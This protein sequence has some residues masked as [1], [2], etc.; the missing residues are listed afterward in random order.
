M[1]LH[2]T[3]SDTGVFLIQIFWAFCLRFSANAY[4]VLYVVSTNEFVCVKFRHAT[5]MVL[6]TLLHMDLYVYL[7]SY[8][9]Y[10]LKVPTSLDLM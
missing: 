5:I 1:K 6:L 7:D 4:S 10:V 9:L 2:W 3:L 8:K